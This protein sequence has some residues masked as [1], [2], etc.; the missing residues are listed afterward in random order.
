MPAGGRR[1]GGLAESIGETRQLDEQHDPPLP[2]A[3]DG[4]MTV[5]AGLTCAV[6]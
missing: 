5:C 6:G 2:E 3:E 4:E 1:T